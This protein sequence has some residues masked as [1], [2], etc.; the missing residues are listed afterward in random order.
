MP[1]ARVADR[2]VRFECAASSGVELTDQ[3]VHQECDDLTAGGV[4]LRGVGRGDSRAE[5]FPLSVRRGLPVD[6]HRRAPVRR[7]RS[8]FTPTRSSAA[9]TTWPVSPSTSA[10]ALPR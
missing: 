8:A 10:T 3:M 9:A 5:L 4:A 1:D 2:Q 7:S 6:I